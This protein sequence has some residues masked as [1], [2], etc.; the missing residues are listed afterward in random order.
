MGWAF[1]RLR[2]VLR[3]FKVRV[4][5]KKRPEISCNAFIYYIFLL[6]TAQRKI[7]GYKEWFCR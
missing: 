2:W 6:K 1:A 5:C 7:S 4:I 3:N